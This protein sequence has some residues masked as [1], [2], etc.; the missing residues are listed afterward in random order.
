MKNP[1]HR[2]EY[3]TGS[4]FRP[5]EL[6]EVG[7]YIL[8]GHRD[9]DICA[10]LD[11]QKTVRETVQ[12]QEDAA[13]AFPNDRANIFTTA[14]T[15]GYDRDTNRQDKE[16][17]HDVVGEDWPNDDEEDND[18]RHF[19]DMSDVEFEEY[20][21]Q[22]RTEADNEEMSNIG[23]R[24]SSEGWDDVRIVHSN[25]IH[26]LPVVTCLCRGPNEAVLDLAFLHFL[27]T[28]FTR[29]RTLFTTAVLDDFRFANLECKAS[30]NQYWQRLRRLTN[31]LWPDTVDNRYRELLRM[32]RLWR[33]MKK[34][35]WAGFGNGQKK[36]ADAA[37]AELSIFCPACPQIG[38]N[39]P[40]DWK[41]D[42]NRY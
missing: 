9:G 33:W 29:L 27:P 13:D 12:I 22:Q 26:R 37:E 32:S 19:E 25:G 4:Y 6:R 21:N 8:I 31:P 35:K 14:G 40:D 42:L 30:A 15:A 38:I 41:N 28:T 36:A 20:M 24:K 5:A 7:V 10:S 2:I 34:L 17:G 11:M 16:D 1:L 39:I 3:W 18:D 23:S